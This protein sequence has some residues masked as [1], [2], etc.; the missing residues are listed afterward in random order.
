MT[1][2]ELEIKMKL[3]EA[4]KRSEAMGEFKETEFGIEALPLL[5]RALDDDFISV[6]LLAIECIGKLGPQALA[7]EPADTKAPKS[8]VAKL[9]SL[10]DR[11]WGYSD[12]KNCYGTALNALVKLGYTNDVLL[13]YIRK[14]LRLD[15]DE[16][17]DSLAALKAIGTPEALRL[18]K[19]AAASRLR[20][21][22]RSYAKKV[23][24]ILLSLGDSQKAEVPKAALQDWHRFQNLI[25][26]GGKLWAGDPHLP[27]ADDGCIAKVPSGKY[28]V[29]CDGPPSRCEAVSKMRVRLEKAKAPTLGKKL[30]ETG[31]D[32]G[33]I[34]VCEIGA[35][36]A[37]YE[38]KGGPE[39]VQKAIDS[40]TGGFGVLKVRSFPELVMPF[41][42]TGSDGT[43]PV[44]ALMSGGKCVGIELSF[45]GEDDVA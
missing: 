5:K 42:P 11:V 4:W 33:T 27:N 9:L 44:F 13:Q 12:Y 25:I 36:E 22:N 3:P 40:L 2:K 39:Q 20:K 35:F 8:L 1:L 31:T 15:D 43:G 19:R 30:G 21:L 38:K 29:E 6:V 14:N 23:Q 41:V 34:G 37:A 16:F 18:L 45:T 32:Y 24:G 7:G 28:V 10:G 26:K 17:L